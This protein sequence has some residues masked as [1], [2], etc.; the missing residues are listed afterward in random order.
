MST[1]LQAATKLEEKVVLVDINDRQIGVAEKLQ[2]HRDGL[3][4][5]AFSVFVLNSQ[6]QLL[7]Q[8][9]A[10]HKYHSG[11]L[12]TNTCCSHPRHEETTVLAAHRRLQEEMGFDCELREIF[13]FVYHAQ[14][15]NDLTEHEFDH[16]FVGYS[17]REPILNPEEAEDWKWIDLK[18]LQAD[19]LKNPQAYTYWLRD[20]CDRFITAIQ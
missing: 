12:W 4:H 1:G 19:L 18:I 9:R 10:Q 13:S 2:A 3:L 17:D 7:L 6:G 15:D 8:K 14:L 11:G 16:V 5:R 20:C